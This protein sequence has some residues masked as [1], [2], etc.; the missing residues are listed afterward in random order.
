MRALDIIHSSLSHL[1]Q[2]G[3]IS[4]IRNMWQVD[5]AIAVHMP[6][7]F[8][9]ASVNG[10]VI[11]LI[12]SSTRDI[13]DSPDSLKFLVGDRL[14]IGIQRDLKASIAKPIAAHRADRGKPV[15]TSLGSHTSRACDH[16]F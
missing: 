16:L 1:A 12:R 5:P 7:R 2:P 9:N 11:R 4:A 15:L 13:L 10:E 3:W 6:E 14:D 8:H